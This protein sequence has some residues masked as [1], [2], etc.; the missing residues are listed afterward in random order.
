M[1]W[2]YRFYVMLLPKLIRKNSSLLELN[3]A[4][5]INSKIIEDSLF[6]VVGS[7]FFE[8]D[9]AEIREHIPI[10]S[11]EEVISYINFFNHLKNSALS[12]EKMREIGPEL[13]SY[14]SSHL[15]TVINDLRN[16]QQDQQHFYT[17]SSF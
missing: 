6:L 3:L 5:Q 11:P 7:P 14:L 8:R 4:S 10:L 2:P 16:Q 17:V 1:K 9:I 13:S 12:Y 15:E